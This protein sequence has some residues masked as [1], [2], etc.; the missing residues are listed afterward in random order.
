MSK[1]AASVIRDY[2]E[3]L[4]YSSEKSISF[5]GERFNNTNLLLGDYDGIDGLKT[6]FTNPA[7]WCFTGTALQEDRRIISVTM[8]SVQGN[9]FPD[10]VILLD[11]G[12]ANYETVIAI[13]FR[14]T[15]RQSDIEQNIGYLIPITTYDVDLARNIGMRSLA[16]ILNEN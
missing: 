7:G 9:R 2:P 11:Y 4:D 6:G 3:I 15:I 10:S 13:H 5:G 8:G 12:F 16:I 1:I 14:T